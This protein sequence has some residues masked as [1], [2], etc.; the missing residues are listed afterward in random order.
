[1]RIRLQHTLFTAFVVLC[2]TITTIAVALMESGFQ[3]ELRDVYRERITSQ[4]ER[5]AEQVR[6]AEGA[7]PATLASDLRGALEDRV[8][9]IDS[10]GFVL[11]DSN[12]PSGQLGGVENHR[13]RP[14]V[15][16]ALAASAAVA[17]HERPS[18]TLEGR[19]FLYAAR[20]SVLDGEPVVV[21]VA[22]PL[23]NIDRVMGRIR[24][25]MV[26]ACVI[27]VFLLALPVAILGGRLADRLVLLVDRLKGAADGTA[28][29]H[30]RSRI[31]EIESL[32]E[33][34]DRTALQVRAGL[35]ALERDRRQ[36]E[37]L[38]E[39]ATE[40]FV[41]LSPEARVIR[42]NEVARGILGIPEG[43][44]SDGGIPFAGVVRHPALRAAVKRVL[45]GTS[46]DGPGVVPRESVELTDN[47]STVAVSVRGL[48]GGGVV[49]TFIDISEIRRMEKVRRDFVANASHELRTPITVIVGLVETLV[50]DEPP[51]ELRTQFL[52]Y[53][54]ENAERLE[55]LIEDL[56]DLSRLEGGGWVADREEVEVMKAA[57]EAW[58]L[59]SPRW[60]DK[61]ISCDFSGD[62]IALCDPAALVNVF[63]NLLDNS[64]R[65]VDEDGRITVQVAG[66]LDDEGRVIVEVTDDGEGIPS[67]LIG[68]VFERFFRA[69][70]SRARE[71]GGTGLGLAIVRHIV[72]A[73]GG[74]VGAESTL[75][76][77]T[78]IRFTLPAWRPNYGDDETT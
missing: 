49:L 32:H 17:F 6:L 61:R 5:I 45:R 62:A 19:D 56:L 59:V 71:R 54:A 3:R 16:D 65:H 72:Q 44:E 55:S 18:A 7:D 4:L 75:G 37:D 2:V 34:V 28:T 53:I 48:A 20:M 22:T 11:G 42:S 73:M 51:K 27:T 12:V 36:A 40:G 21:R 1:M 47:G 57:R 76:E 15:R 68:R 33:G 66:E 25:V 46:A 41:M 10:A 9:I 8:T 14:E 39:T 26:W 69:D 78:T 43:A 52:G 38:I 63:R 29:P 50:E 24:L 23:E 58:G 67:N 31:V 35:E 70:H 13:G 64:S 74:V 30:R 77:G 60:E